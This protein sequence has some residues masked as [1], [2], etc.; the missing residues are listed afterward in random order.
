[1]GGVFVVFVNNFLSILCADM[2]PV[3][4]ISYQDGMISLSSLN[5]RLAT[6]LG[7]TSSSTYICGC[8][9]S[10]NLIFCA[11][12]FRGLCVCSDQT[13]YIGKHYYHHFHSNL[14]IT[15]Q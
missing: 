13:F 15:L 10:R 11:V 3:V 2:L 6:I 12:I 9:A 4:F 7:N 14:N 5:G 1:M 8:M